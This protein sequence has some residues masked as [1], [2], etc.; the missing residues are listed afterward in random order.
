MNLRHR[1]YVSSVHAAIELSTVTKLLSR[2]WALTRS[3][4]QA[5]VGTGPSFDGESKLFDFGQLL[6]VTVIA[7]PLICR[8]Q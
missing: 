3:R 8:R 5:G 7:V 4:R 6:T 2:D 1:R